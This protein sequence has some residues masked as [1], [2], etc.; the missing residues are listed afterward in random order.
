LYASTRATFKRKPAQT[1]GSSLPHVAN[2][3]CI[4]CYP[5]SHAEDPPSPDHAS[6]P[7]VIMLDGR[8]CSQQVSA[9]TLAESS[10]RNMQATGCFMAALL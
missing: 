1:R 10:D 7:S 9:H 6:T 2:F 5:N 3:S 4:G 8:E